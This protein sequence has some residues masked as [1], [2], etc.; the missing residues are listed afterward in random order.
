MLELALDNHEWVK[1]DKWEAM[2]DEWTLTVDVLRHHREKLKK[3]YGNDTQLMFLCGADLLE[4]FLIPGVWKNDHVSK[5]C[6]VI[7]CGTKSYMIILKNCKFD[8]T[9]LFYSR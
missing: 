6:H 1:L 7:L 4:S 5:K 8:F 9:Q 3:I 2:K